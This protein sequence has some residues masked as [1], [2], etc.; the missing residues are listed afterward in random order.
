MDLNSTYLQSILT[1]SGYEKDSLKMFTAFVLF[2]Y[3]HMIYF[4][5]IPQVIFNLIVCTVILYSSQVISSMITFFLI[6]NDYVVGVKKTF[7]HLSG[8][9]GY[10]YNIYLAHVKIDSQL[11]RCCTAMGS[12]TRVLLVSPT[13]IKA[14]NPY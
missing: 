2:L 8:P 3:N 7:V 10:R 6:P 4:I 11:L 5:G 13:K 14:H 12:S 1:Q 9:F